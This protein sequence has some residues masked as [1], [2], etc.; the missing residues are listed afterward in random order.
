MRS[1]L[2]WIPKKSPILDIEPTEYEPCDHFIF[3][4]QPNPTITV[5]V[6]HGGAFL[7]VRLIGMTEPPF[8]AYVV[9]DGQ[10]KLATDPNHISDMPGMINYI[11]TLDVVSLSARLGIQQWGLVRLHC[12]N[13]DAVLRDWPGPISIQVWTPTEDEQALRNMKQWYRYD[14]GIFSLAR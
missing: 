9:K 6:T 13:S 8:A 10:A 2:E 5:P 12:D 11:Q 1:A 7:R 14:E 4:L 3:V